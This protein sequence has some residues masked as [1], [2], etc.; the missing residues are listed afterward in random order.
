MIPNYKQ[1]QSVNQEIMGQICDLESIETQEISVKIC[2][3][4]YNIYIITH[5]LY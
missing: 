5:Y 1:Y 4:F 2:V 3:M